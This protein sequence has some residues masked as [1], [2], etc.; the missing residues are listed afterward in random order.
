MRIFVAGSTGVLGRNLIPLLLQ[1]GNTVVAL[2]RSREKAQHIEA[3]GAEIVMGD[4]LADET[5]RDLPKM[6]QGCDAVLHIATAIP[7]NMAAPGAWTANTRLRI[8]GTRSLL[9]ASLQSGVTHYL[10]QSIVMAYPDCGD[11]W[12]SEDT[13]LDTS[14]TRASVTEPVRQMEGMVRAVDPTRLRWS[15]LRGGSF[16]GPGTG[17]ENLVTRLQAGEVTVPCDGS[18]YFSPIHVLDM[19]TA[20]IASLTGAPAGSIFNIVAEPLRYGDY[21]DRLADLLHV[22][23]PQR[24]PDQPCPPSHRCSNE[25]ARQTLGWQ[26]VHSTFAVAAFHR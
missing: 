24:T 8:E 17:Q 20:C 11:Q 25:A 13:P 2:A 5:V 1:Q 21:L 18:Y 3:A 22:R 12:I 4:L 6:V 16:V 9:D 15:I 7:R 14:P 10:Q 23:H 19:A 26:P